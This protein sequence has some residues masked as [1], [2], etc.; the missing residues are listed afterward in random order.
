[1]LRR[2]YKAAGSLQL[3]AGQDAGAEAAI[4]TMRDIFANVDTDAVL[5]LMLRMHSTP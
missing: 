3:S 5:L 4:H 2:C 1:M